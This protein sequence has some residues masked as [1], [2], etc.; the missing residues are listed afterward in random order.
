MKFSLTIAD[1]LASLR[2]YEV[3]GDYDREISGIAGLGEATE[4]DLS[5]LSSAKYASGV[6]S[7]NASV[8]LVPE[9]YGEKAPRGKLYVKVKNP[10][11]SLAFVCERIEAQLRP[12]PEAGVHP[13][14]VI[15]PEAVVDP[16]AHVGPLC[17]VEK[18]ARIGSGAVLSSQVYI[19][20]GACIGKG[21]WLYPH[22][23]VHRYCE[24]GDHCILH[25]GVV[26]GGD[27]FGYE[28]DAGQHRKV[29]QIG[30]VVVEAN[31]EIGANSTIDRARLTETRI[32]SGTKIDNLVQIAHN[33]RI[34]SHCFL[35]AQVGI[36]GSTTLG[37]YVVMAGQSGTVGHIHIADGCQVGGQS[38]IAK[39]LSAGT[40]VTGTPATEFQRQRRLEAM[41]RRLPQLFERVKEIDQLVRP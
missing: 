19:G 8:I 30:N 9:Q 16:G 18:D 11:L 29:P 27:G 33:V 22:V 12:R 39:S 2:D 13:S 17:V 40:V 10:S 28:T 5:F 32:G 41:V 38:G 26:I 15:H 7:S 3:E 34:G 31:V 23:S 37:N 24:I 36:S 4:G 25:S 6:P 21:V 35:C 14:A 20:A 1:L